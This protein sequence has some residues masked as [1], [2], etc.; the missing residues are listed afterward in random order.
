LTCTPTPTTS[1]YLTAREA[2]EYLAISYSTF[3]KKRK[4]IRRVPGTRRFRREDLDAFA[5]STKPRRQ[6]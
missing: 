6:V 3:R 5:E 4:F 2:S 1:V